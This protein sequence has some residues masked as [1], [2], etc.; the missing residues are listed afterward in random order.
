M[1]YLSFIL[2]AFVPVVLVLSLLR[3]SPVAGVALKGRA[4]RALP[5]ACL[6]IFA[7]A[8]PWLNYL[9]FRD[10]WQHIT[11][12]SSGMIGLVPLETYL[13]LLFIPL[14][15]A[16]VTYRL[17]ERRPH[18]PASSRPGTRVLGALVYAAFAIA[19]VLFL[20][21]GTYRALYLGLILTWAC[22]LLAA[23][24]GWAGDHYREHASVIV[25]AVIL[26]TV[27]LGIADS[28]A[29]AGGLWSMSPQHT[30]GLSF[31]L[32]VER[33]VFFV[34]TN[35]LVVQSVLLFLHADAITHRRTR[36]TELQEA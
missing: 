6:L 21:S 31:G 12:E 10:V 15:T 23:M 19:G 28:L 25:P 30:L 20:L 8:V 33:L 3:R 4:R 34:V 2:L 22:P 24:W 36:R 29:S 11:G 18:L 16:T 17:L 32:P 9:G 27:Y 13:L 1:T 26:P 7:Y 35:L 14:L 5:L